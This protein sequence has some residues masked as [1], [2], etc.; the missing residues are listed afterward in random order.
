MCRR[1]RSEPE[2]V[3]GYD[4][5]DNYDDGEEVARRR[6]PWLLAGLAG[7]MVVIALA[8]FVLLR[9][10]LSGR[11]AVVAPEPTLA[12]TSQPI[13]TAHEGQVSAPTAAPPSSPTSSQASAQNPVSG[14]LATRYTYD[15]NGNLRTR[16]DENGA[17]TKYE[18]DALNRLTAI[19][20]PDQS[21][22]T[23]TYDAAGR[24]TA[25]TDFLGTT[26][27]VYDIHDRL[28]SIT[29]PNNNT[30]QYEYDP[31]GLVTGLIYPDGA[32]VNYTWNEDGQLSTVQDQTGITS[33]QYDAGGRLIRRTLSNGVTTGYEYDA[34][35]RLASIE[36]R[37]PDGDLLIGF[38][39]EY[40]AVN[41]RTQL[42][43]TEANDAPQVTRYEYDA[44]DR[45]TRVSYPDGE[46]VSYQYD[47]IGNRTLQQSSTGG[48]TRY[49]YNTADQ[50]IEA[51]GPEGVLTYHYDANG[52]LVERLDGAGNAVQYGWDFENRLTKVISGTTNAEFQYDGDGRRLAKVVNGQRTEYV[53]HG[54]LVPQVVAVSTG[55]A[56]ARVLLGLQHFAESGAD[57]TRFYLEDALGS[58]VGTTN[59]AGAL[60]GT[61][62]YEAFGR[63]RASTLAASFGFTGEQIDAETGLM[64]LRARYYDTST[65]A[66]ISQDPYIYSMVNS[67]ALNRYAYVT[68]NPVN[69]VDPLGL[70]GCA[71]ND[72]PANLST[73]STRAQIITRPLGGNDWMT[74][75]G[76]GAYLFLTFGIGHTDVRVGN[77]TVGFFP[78]GWNST[79]QSVYPAWLSFTQNVNL[80][81]GYKETSLPTTPY[82]FCGYNCQS[83]AAEVVQRLGGQT[84]GLY[85]PGKFLN[86]VVATV[87]GALSAVGQAAVGGVS[88][89]QAAT[90]LADLNDISGA[91]YDAATGQV[92]LIGRKD[93]TLPSM[94][95]DDMAVAIRAI[96]LGENSGVTMV[97]V[98]PTMHDITQRVEYFGHTENT[99][100]GQVM[101]EADRYLK[102]LAG[103]QDT[104]TG[105]PLSPNVPDFTSEVDLMIALKVREVPWHRN[106]FVPG[107]VVLTRST[108]GQSMI[109]DRATIRLESRF[110]EFDANGNPR[111]IRGS[112]PVTDRFTRFV[113]D[114]YAE[115][116]AGKPE[117]AEL[118][119][120][121]KIVGIVKWLRDNEIPVDLDW[122][123]TYRIKE[124]ETPATT[125]GLLA[126]RSAPDGSYAITS[127]GGVGYD[128]PNTYDEDTSGR[129]A[130]LG[131]AALASRPTD[132]PITW[133][134]EQGGERL[135]AVA[136][137][138]APSEIIGGDLIERT[139]VAVRAAGGQTID[140][141]RRA[142]SLTS[143]PGPLGRG[144]APV[145]YSLAFWRSPVLDNPNAFYTRATLTDRSEKTEY[146]LADDGLFYPADPASPYRVMGLTGS[147]RFEPLAASALTISPGLP[148]EPLDVQDQSERSVQYTGFAVIRKDGGRLAFDPTGRLDATRD[149]AGN[150][151][152]YTYQETRLVAA[153]DDAG[154]GVELA[155]DEAGR[156]TGLTTSDDRAVRY[157]YDVSGNLTGVFDQT[158]MQLEGYAYDADGRVSRITDA[159]GRTVLQNGYDGLG[160]LVSRES[161]QEGS[162]EVHYDAIAGTATYTGWSGNTITRRYNK[163]KRLVAETGSDGATTT[164]EY[165][166]QDRLASVT[167]PNGN[168]TGFTYDAR[169]LL[170]EVDLPLGGRIR[171]LNYNE[172]GV[173]ELMVDA[174]GRMTLGTVDAQGWVVAETSGLQVETESPDGGFSYFEVNPS[175]S[176]YE[177]DRAGRLSAAKDPS[178][179]VTRFG[180]DEV[181]NLT[182]VALPGGGRITQAF[183]ARSQLTAITDASGLQVQLSYDAQ[184]QL[185]EV[186]TPSG[187]TRLEY[188]K[189]QLT[190]L[191]DALGRTSR[192]EYHPA[193]QLARVVDPIG[194]STSLEYDSAGKLVSIRDA[195]GRSLAYAYDAKGQLVSE[196]MASS[197]TMVSGEPVN[198]AAP[199]RTSSLVDEVAGLITAQ[200][201]DAGEVRQQLAG[202][203]VAQLESLRGSSGSGRL[204][205]QVLDQAGLDF[206]RGVGAKMLPGTGPLDL[207]VYGSGERKLVICREDAAGAPGRAEALE[208]VRRHYWLQ[209]E[210]SDRVVI[211][212]VTSGTS[213]KMLAGS[214]FAEITPR[215]LETFGGRLARLLAFLPPLRTRA[216]LSAGELALRYPDRL[217]RLLLTRKLMASGA[218]VIGFDGDLTG[219]N[220]Q[221]VFPNARVYRT[222]GTDVE[223]ILRRRQRLESLKINLAD[224]AVLNG[225]PDTADGVEKIGMNVGDTA[226]W[227]AANDRWRTTVEKRGAV[228]TSA[229]ADTLLAALGSNPVVVV[230]VAHSDGVSIYLP[231]S[232]RFDVTSLSAEV[233]QAIARNAPVVWLFSCRTGSIRD[234]QSLAQGLLDA[235][236]SS[237]IAPV[238]NIEAE[239]SAAVLDRFLEGISKGKLLL[240]ALDDALRDALGVWHE[241]RLGR[242]P[243]DESFEPVAL[244]PSSRWSQP[245]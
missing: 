142:N 18:Y 102:G 21:S 54:I 15:P 136:L 49:T 67:Q 105:Q 89:D 76:L 151:V 38:R 69:L 35:G 222:Q 17:F 78:T 182:E 71:S 165:D 177:Y 130:A 119:R 173:P 113:T 88:L 186:T 179:S 124:V 196:T 170:T 74:W 217:G 241:N 43:R 155:Y 152:N 169:S 115:L 154:R 33:Y 29:D 106:W 100:F 149:L 203:D 110:I 121:A 229:N 52:N 64:F 183:D 164:Y 214:Q 223:A 45:L 128:T 181:G 129:A 156:L 41:N 200:P 32:A 233:R 108:D 68:N 184:G 226:K 213:L 176:E 34:A 6:S 39:Y 37:G 237:V 11:S 132:M 221:R 50:L 92:I 131:T 180:Y 208:K 193:G 107:E 5:A 206:L 139:D 91:T 7:G 10:P 137:N 93:A 175:T 224:V 138:L 22:V 19:R 162:A 202:L 55:D 201:S 167:D 135:T 86:D 98:D 235:G 26:A 82:N 72:P 141:A 153:K 104:L 178:G 118:M 3:Y 240:D 147:D 160:R 239:G 2:E 61:V 101:F 28:V 242:A 166:P 190:S 56:R 53:Q 47:A 65:G 126:Q 227:R 215:E 23:Y 127:M 84:S 20:Y 146:S 218:G 245:T 63:S 140:F 80:P 150:R 9:G 120:L 109:F 204:Y 14:S 172:F 157:A 158:G 185:A 134:F 236:A 31:R 81:T 125:P 57:G 168:T 210:V 187:A 228:A 58:M 16:T 99:H 116:A 42:T 174:L 199:E 143:A 62:E 4:S 123:N 192:Y 207:Q 198:A 133:S 44:L 195:K 83:A 161:A 51:A 24:R 194:G 48:D 211:S 188:T 59:A 216:A 12:P 163:R 191:T 243:S 60:L 87:G 225:I 209:S 189:G 73:N 238:G 90:V 144:W 219:L 95:P 70:A 36:H 75:S 171:W 97:P 117:L 30:L 111:D 25:M 103:G 77:S 1:K 79:P 114:H 122:M 232:S 159:A 148:G 112:S 205:G 8:L 244:R 94:D 145:E 96:Y 66:F 13:Q 230:L 234:G 197:E 40:N 231:D 220:F 212:L 46:V 85:L 27:Y